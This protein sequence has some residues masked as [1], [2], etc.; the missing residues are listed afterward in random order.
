MIIVKQIH[1]KT[2]PEKKG[3]KKY[4]SVLF[5]IKIYVICVRKKSIGRQSWKCFTDVRI[6]LIIVLLE[7]RFSG[8]LCEKR[9]VYRRAMKHCSGELLVTL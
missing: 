8:I 1:V 6:V 9:N 3:L 4:L 7:D 5:V 2:C